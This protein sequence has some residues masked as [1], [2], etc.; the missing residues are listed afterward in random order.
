M[1]MPAVV[2]ALL[3]A[4]AVLVT[5]CTRS[6]PVSPEPTSSPTR[7]A[8]PSPVPTPVPTAMPIPPTPTSMPAATSILPTPTPVPWVEYREPNGLFALTYPE[9]WTLHIYVSEDGGFYQ[10]EPAANRRFDDAVYNVASNSGAILS[11]FVDNRTRTWDIA[12]EHARI[13]RFD[14]GPKSPHGP[15]AGAREC[16]FR[17]AILSEGRSLWQGTLT[18]TTTY[19]YRSAGI[20]PGF[21]WFCSDV[22]EVKTL[23]TLERGGYLIHLSWDYYES[24]DPRLRETLERIAS[25]IRFGEQNKGVTSNRVLTPTPAPQPTATLAPPATLAPMTFRTY[26]HPQGLWQITYPSTWIVEGPQGSPQNSSLEEVTFNS[27][28]RFARLYVEKY[29]S[30][31]RTYGDSSSWCRNSLSIFGSSKSFRLISDERTAVGSYSGC[32]YTYYY[33]GETTKFMR[34]SVSFVVGADAYHLKGATSEENW[35]DFKAALTQ[36]IYSFKLLR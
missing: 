3:L 12:E 8:T 22:D 13:I 24:I 6:L 26:V 9:D 29:V 23:R 11:I 7:T 21:G 2:S 1:Q 33:E 27:N 30:Y 25:L 36:S 28:T 20:K 17:L 18:Y 10:R 14:A 35:P 15:I 5:A 32:E 16:P 31:G 34:I 4:I 19:L